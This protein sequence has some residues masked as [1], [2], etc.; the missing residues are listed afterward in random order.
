MLDSRGCGLEPHC[1]HCFVSLT[2][3]FILCLVLVRPR[4]TRPG[5]TEKVLTLTKRIQTKQVRLIRNHIAEHTILPIIQYIHEAMRNN[6]I[7]HQ[8]H[9]VILFVIV[10]TFS[11]TF[12]K[13]IS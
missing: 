10:V 5:M 9:A 2:R 6:M 1:Q 7:A 8:Y 3:H 11:F 4:K 12:G 13:F